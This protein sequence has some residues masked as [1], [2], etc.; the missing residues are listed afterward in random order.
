MVGMACATS[1]FSFQIERRKN[2]KIKNEETNLEAKVFYL[3]FSLCELLLN[4]IIT[5][6]TVPN[7]HESYYKHNKP[8]LLWV[9][10]SIF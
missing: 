9:F 10:V 7:S 5:I 2:L 1:E 3:E 8:D 4:S 6:F